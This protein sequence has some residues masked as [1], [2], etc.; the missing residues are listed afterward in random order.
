MTDM[1]LI[2]F[3]YSLGGFV[4]GFEVRAVL[5]LYHATHSWSATWHGLKLFHL[6]CL[7]AS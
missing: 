4:V 7:S 5:T 1:L 3:F 6:D 2:H